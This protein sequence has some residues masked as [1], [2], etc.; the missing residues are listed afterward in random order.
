MQLGILPNMRL[1]SHMPAAYALVAYQTAYLRYY[2]PV[3]FMAA[4][5]TSV[6]EIRQKVAI[7]YPDMSTDGH[8]DPAAGH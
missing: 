8:P 5:M 1:I 4:L 3:E 7:V 6:I 2:Y